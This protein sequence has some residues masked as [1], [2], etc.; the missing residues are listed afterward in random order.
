MRRKYDSVVVGSGPNGF[1]AAITMQQAGLSVLLIEGKETLG[2]GVRSAQLTL[3]GFIHD[4][5]SAVYPLGEDSPVF[6]SF[7]LQ[8]FGLEYITPENAI[9]HPFDDGSAVAV[10]YSIDETAA[11]LGKDAT[12]YKK[13]FSPLVKNWRSISSAFLGPLHVSGYSNAK[14]RFACYAVSPVVNFVKHQFA[15]AEARALFAGMGAHTM[16]PLDTLTTSSMAIVLNLMAHVNGWPLPKGGAQQITNA[17]AD[18]F[19]KLGGEIQ[20][21]NMV[22]SLKQLPEAKTLLLD[23]TPAQLLSIAGDQL[24]AFY[25]WQA[26]RYQYGEGVFKIDWALSQPAPF[27][28]SKCREAVTIHIGGSFE[29]IYQGEA[30]VG[31]GKLPKKPFVLFVQP[32]IADP[33]R[34][35]EGKHIAWAYCHVPAGSTVDMTVAIENQVE[36]FAPGFKDCIL[37]RHVMNTHDMQDHNPND[38]GGDINGGA[39]IPSQLF[40]R[41]VLRFSPYRTSAKNIYICSSSTPPGG[42]VHGICGYYAARR[43]L[44]DH[45]KIKLPWL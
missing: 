10:R 9:A 4:V 41:P 7:Q 21:G 3:P 37:A 14:A 1:A 13:I 5:C 29:D 33:S 15:A 34:A 30:M 18:Y 28:N 17:L 44:K 36:R 45:F 40:T 43:T 12:N 24:S 26:K 27:I 42:G 2:G 6:K 25:K 22:H 31:K 23:V 32:T 16:L 20:T 35:P 19:K 11:Q 39:A 8:Q 38:V